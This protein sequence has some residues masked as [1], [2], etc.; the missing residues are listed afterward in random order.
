MA[1][2]PPTYMLVNT[3]NEPIP[4]SHVV[5]LLKEINP[6]LGLKWFPPG[7][8]LPK[9]S[10]SIIEAWTPNDTRWKMIQEGKMDPGAAF[11][12]LGYLPED[13][14]VEQA[15]GYLERYF[16]SWKGTRADCGKYLEKLNQY[17][18]KQ[19]AAAV[20]PTMDY[21]EEMLA[22]NAKTM[23][24]GEGKRVPKIFVTD[25]RSKII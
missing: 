13:C 15:R 6:R 18:L 21:M 4:P 10:W 1:F 17:N 16:I 24:R 14:P 22:T 3:H 2:P 7:D 8:L 12:A 25:K 5:K 20:Q 23:F 11:D 19:Q 9:G